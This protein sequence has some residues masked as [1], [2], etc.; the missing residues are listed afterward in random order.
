MNK[1]ELIGEIA[2]ECGITKML[3]KEVFESLFSNLEKGIKN[4]DKVYV[5]GFGTFTKSERS[6]RMGRNPKTG[7]QVAIA[8]KTTVKFKSSIV[9]E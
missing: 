7:E 2:S 3:A 9:I 5:P 6:A 1:A 8:A 4:S